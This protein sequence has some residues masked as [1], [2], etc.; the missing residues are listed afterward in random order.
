[1]LMVAMLLSLI[2]LPFTLVDCIDSVKL[3]QIKLT[4]QSSRTFLLLSIH[5]QHRSDSVPGDLA[6]EAKNS[7]GLKGRMGIAVN[8]LCTCIERFGPR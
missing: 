6:V 4:N 5:S 7:E 3:R 1:M 2:V 8:Y